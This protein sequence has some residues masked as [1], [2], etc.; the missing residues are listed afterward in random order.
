MTK[1]GGLVIVT[2]TA[3]AGLGARDWGLGASNF[4]TRVPS[5]AFIAFR[6]SPLSSLLSPLSSRLSCFYFRITFSDAVSA[7]MNAGRLNKRSAYFI[8]GAHGLGSWMP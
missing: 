1:I 4:K 5:L 6:L 8:S 2:C 3:K 7:S